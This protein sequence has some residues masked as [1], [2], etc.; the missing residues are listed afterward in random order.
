MLAV[1]AREFYQS[2]APSAMTQ[3]A[4]HSNLVPSEA[5]H[6]GLT[7]YS[8]RIL[9]SVMLLVCRCLSASLVCF[10]PPLCGTSRLE[11]MLLE[12]LA[13]SLIWGSEEA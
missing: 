9:Q 2:P 8:E 13:G 3:P 11:E 10:V 4:V 7:G 12:S 1:A 6:I 5:S